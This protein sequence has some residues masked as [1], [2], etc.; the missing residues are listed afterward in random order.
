MNTDASTVEDI[1]IHQIKERLAMSCIESSGERFSIFR[2]LSFTLFRNELDFWERSNSAT[3]SD[4]ISSSSMT[5]LSVCWLNGCPPTGLTVL[6]FDI[7]PDFLTWEDHLSSLFH[8]EEFDE[9][10]LRVSPKLFAAHLTSQRYFLTFRFGVLRVFRCSRGKHVRIPY[11]A[12][13]D[14]IHHRLRLCCDSFFTCIFLRSFRHRFNTIH[15]TMV[16]LIT[17]EISLCQS[18]CELVFGVNVFDLDLG[19]QIDSIKQKIK[20]NSVGSGNM[21]H[22]RTSFL[23]HNL[24]HCFVVFKH[25]QQSFLTRR[26]HVW[27]N[28]INIVHQI[29]EHSLRLL[30]FLSCVRCWTNCSLWLWFCV[31]KNCDDQIR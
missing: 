9:Q 6:V 25:I 21:S 17:C 19:V 20:S 12:S 2:N 15:G 5:N 4:S 24:D 16:P 30:S 7:S 22:G 18:V 11:A 26:M 28:K 29:I 8:S 1:N 27:G 23:Y 3:L 31:S 13:R 14:Q 10:A